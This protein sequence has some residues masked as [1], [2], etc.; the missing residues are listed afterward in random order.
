MMQIINIDFV[1][2]IYRPS[3]V[4]GALKY[5]QYGKRKMFGLKK[6]K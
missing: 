6:Q 5:D 1:L 4:E 3:F 2:F